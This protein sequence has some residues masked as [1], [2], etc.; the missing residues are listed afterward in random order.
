MF[1][2]YFYSRFLYRFWTT[3]ACNVYCKQIIVI[4]VCVFIVFGFVYTHLSLED[5]SVNRQFLI[6]RLYG[7][8]SSMAL[9]S[10]FHKQFA[11]S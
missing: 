2:F 11:S 8:T 9:I 1:F 4:G 5:D 10:H 3:S 7:L 6:S